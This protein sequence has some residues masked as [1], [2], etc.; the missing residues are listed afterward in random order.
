MKNRL[1]VVF[2]LLFPLACQGESFNNLFIEKIDG[3]DEQIY[4]SITNEDIKLFCEDRIKSIQT[5]IDFS[6]RFH[7]VYIN[8]PDYYAS[9]NQ[10]YALGQVNTYEEILKKITEN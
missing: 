1:F 10:G 6:F 3:V 4:W 2:F 7:R 5:I 9:F 8:D